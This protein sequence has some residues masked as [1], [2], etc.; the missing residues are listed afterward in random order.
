M[1]NGSH[2]DVCETTGVKNCGESGRFK[3]EFGIETESVCLRERRRTRAAV[4]KKEERRGM[5]R[6][7][8]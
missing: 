6:K 7:T 4:V 5:E 3:E 2:S 8:E 1:L